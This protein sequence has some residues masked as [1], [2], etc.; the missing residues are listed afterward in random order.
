MNTPTRPL[1][2]PSAWSD[3][4]WNAARERRFVVQEC[5]ECSRLNMYPKLF[6]P[7]C[8]SD[9]LGWRDSEGKGEIYAVTAQL[10]GPPTG[11]AD[12]LPY[13]IAII[14]LNE[15][16]Q[17]MSNIVGEGAIDAKIGDRVTVDFE[18]AGDAVLP[19]FRLETMA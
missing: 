3:G 11:F 14:R 5:H 12:R 19:V 18:E 2:H 9:R 6:C 16:V 7:H 10:A 13:V 8:L 17:L 4:Y 15:G 1:P